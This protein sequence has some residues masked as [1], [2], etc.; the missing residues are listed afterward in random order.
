[1]KLDN[2]VTFPLDALD[3]TPYLSGPLQHGGEA[4][5][6]YGSVCHYGSV[7]GGHY[8][9]FAKQATSGQWHHFNDAQVAARL[10]EGGEQDSAYVLFYRR[11]GLGL[12]VVLEGEGGKGGD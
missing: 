12:G 2:R 4:F 1:M 9:S 7:S 5:E 10:P 6:L 8:T 11:S 3:L